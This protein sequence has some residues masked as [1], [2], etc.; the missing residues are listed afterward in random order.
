M[1]TGRTMSVCHAGFLTPL[2]D[3]VGI[4]HDSGRAAAD[5][6]GLPRS[7]NET[8]KLQTVSMTCHDT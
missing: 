1:F 8:E 2:K 3:A 5:V 6:A 7:Q 4:V